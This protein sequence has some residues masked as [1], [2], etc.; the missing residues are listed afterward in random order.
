[1][2]K[3]LDT[4]NDRWGSGALRSAGVPINPDWVMHREMM[5]PSYT[6]KLDQFWKVACK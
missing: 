5:S 2:M 4:I 3:V 6:T 1:M